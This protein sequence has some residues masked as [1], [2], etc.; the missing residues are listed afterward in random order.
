MSI[1]NT[2]FSNIQI[3]DVFEEYSG[4]NSF[5]NSFPKDSII[6][7]E[8][9][10]GKKEGK[11][12]VV[13]GEGIRLAELNFRNDQLNGNCIFLNE[14]GERVREVNF[15]NGVAEGF[16]C[17]YNKKSISKMGINKNGKAFSE[18]RKHANNSQLLEEVV[19]SKVI[20]VCKYSKEYKKDGLC[21]FYENDE[22][23]II[24]Y[25]TDAIPY[26]SRKKEL[27]YQYKYQILSY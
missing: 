27:A 24:D 25:K 11:G 18:L 4:D 20:S 26:E 17:E 15:E 23:V 14:Y 6:Q 13:S 16:Y 5:V 12:N 9:I 22:I 10:N 19:N 2:S 8:V 1:S 21:T 3:R 7:V